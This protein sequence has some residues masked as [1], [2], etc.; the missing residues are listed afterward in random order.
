[1][2]NSSRRL[3][4]ID[5]AKGLAIFLVVL[6]HI[7]AREP[8][9]DADW[10]LALKQVIYGFHMCFFMF[11][12]GVVFFHGYRPFKER[13]AYAEFVR[14]RFVRLMPA[15]LLFGSIVVLGKLAAAQ[16]VHV[17]NPVNSIGAAFG[18]FLSPMTSPAA[19]LWYVYCLFLISVLVPWILRFTN[20]SRW[21]AFGLAVGVHFIPL[22]HTFALYEVG[23]YLQFFLLG[24]LVVLD[25]ERYVLML[26][27]YALM[28]IG[29]FAVGLLLIDPGKDQASLLGLL[30]IPALH[31][32]VRLPLI[33][34]SALLV[35]LGAFSFPIYLMNTLSIGATKA[36]VLRFMSWDGHNF[37]IVGPL[38]LVAGL[39]IPIFLKKTII[40]R[41]PVLDRI[42]S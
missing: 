35:T 27:R 20:H 5:R 12:S 21:I 1:M 7:V 26:D 6:G 33:S 41:F 25:Y 32:I 14:K 42:T 38:L 23:K 40:P 4:D 37:L 24:G 17:D 34:R 36:M 31:A 29:V 15:Y 8:P 2:T 30:S 11:L 13:G 19:F 39:A 16:F 9:R 10:Y 18:I 22:P 3:A 28:F